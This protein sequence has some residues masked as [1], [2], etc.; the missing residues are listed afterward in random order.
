[1]IHTRILQKAH[2]VARN[3]PQNGAEQIGES[4]EGG[5]VCQSLSKDYRR[6]TGGDRVLLSQNLQ[7]AGGISTCSDNLISAY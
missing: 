4:G 3:P 2:P 1:M 5:C 7:Q 6:R